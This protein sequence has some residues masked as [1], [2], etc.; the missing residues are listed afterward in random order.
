MVKSTT[1]SMDED[2]KRGTVETP[3]SPGLSFNAYATM[4]SRQL[5]TQRRVPFSTVAPEREPT[6]ETRMAMVAA[7][8]KALGLPPGVASALD[9]GDDALDYLEA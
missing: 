2:L 4:A 7:E 5:F 1:I 9:G 3:D 8:A 6:E